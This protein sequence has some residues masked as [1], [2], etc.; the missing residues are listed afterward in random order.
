MK[1]RWAANAL[2]FAVAW[3][4]T[5]CEAWKQYS[6]SWRL[7]DD[8]PFGNQYQPAANANVQ[9]LALRDQRDVVVVYDEGRE[10]KETIRRRAYMLLDNEKRVQKGKPPRFVALESTN[11]LAAISLTIKTETNSATPGSITAIMATNGHEFTLYRDGKQAGHF[12]LPVYA[13]SK[14]KAIRACVMPA[15]VLVDGTVVVAVVGVSAGVIA[16]VALAESNTTIKN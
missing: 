7:I 14:G 15:A 3:S 9:L 11:G 12:H 16:W 2:V 10:G 4:L 13:D 5:G 8:N 1:T 6:L